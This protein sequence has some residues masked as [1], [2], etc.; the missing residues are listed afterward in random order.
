MDKGLGVAHLSHTQVGSLDSGELWQPEESSSIPMLNTSKESPCT[1]KESPCQFSTASRMPKGEKFYDNPDS[2]EDVQSFSSM[3]SMLRQYLSA[4]SP[5]STSHGYMIHTESILKIAEGIRNPEMPEK[6]VGDEVAQ[7]KVQANNSMVFVWDLDETLIIFQT[8][9]NGQYAKLFSGFKD[10]WEGT[11]L[12]HRW[13]QLILE[14]CD[15]YFFYKQVEDWNEPNLMALQDYDDGIDLKSYDFDHDNLGLIPDATNKRK[16]AYRHR[17]VR[18]LYSKGLEKLLNHEQMM[19]WQLLYKATD[20]YTDGWL[21]AGRQ[22]LQECERAN[23]VGEDGLSGLAQAMGKLEMPEDGHRLASEGN[24]N[25]L[26][27][28]STLIPSLVKCLLFRLDPYFH[29]SNIYSS[30]EVGKLQCFRWIYERLSIVKP[31]KFCVIGDGIDESEAAQMLA[32]P[33]VKISTGPYSCHRLPSLSMDI[34]HHTVTVGY[35]LSNK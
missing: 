7:T 19:E 26:V 14:V 9:S 30:R 35:E 6:T 11:M 4:P 28:S 10:P 1:S 15:D 24:C 27:T 16:L 8:L 23:N 33:F 12:G 2:E 34:L 25:I 20:R 29:P 13:E 32:W 21:S 17:F 31:V 22:M 18:H 3:A 5:D